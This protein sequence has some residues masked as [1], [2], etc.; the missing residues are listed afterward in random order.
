[1]QFSSVNNRLN[2]QNAFSLG[3]AEDPSAGALKFCGVRA[4]DRQD[5][6]V[7]LQC[8]VNDKRKLE[9]I[10]AGSLC[11]LVS[12]ISLTRPFFAAERRQKIWARGQLSA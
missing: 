5:V 11:P 4:C 6:G 10:L 12:R 3:Y 8:L 1:M 7:P 9:S 2:S